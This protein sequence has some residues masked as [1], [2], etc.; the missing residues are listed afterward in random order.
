M[1]FDSLM[2]FLHIVG[3]MTLFVGFGMEWSN[4]NRLRMAATI[5]ELREAVRLTTRNLPLNLVAALA[6]LPPGIYLARRMNVLDQGWIQ[7]AMGT[8]FLMA[9]LGGLSSH[10][11]RTIRNT[12]TSEVGPLPGDLPGR[13]NVTLLAASF[14]VRVALA[15]GI[16]LLMVAKPEFES[17][18]QVI[19]AALT[20]GG[21]S[22]A[23]AW[24]RQRNRPVAETERP[25]IQ[26]GL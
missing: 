6:I 23:V 9:V 4:L 18:L 11:M 7:A 3:A 25:P 1:T 15:L 10:R 19:G 13:M 17:S 21:G 16:V 12:S 20:V 26:E 8:I 5:E 14:Y 22:T 24:L 2:L